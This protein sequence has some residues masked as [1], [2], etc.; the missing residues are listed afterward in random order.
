MTVNKYTVLKVVWS[1]AIFSLLLWI[2]VQNNLSQKMINLGFSI[3]TDNQ[4]IINKN[5]LNKCK[6]IDI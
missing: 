1:I 5:I 2:T 6:G 3:I 4:E